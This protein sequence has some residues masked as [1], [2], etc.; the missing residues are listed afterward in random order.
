M[1]NFDEFRFFT[2]LRQSEQLALRTRDC[3]LEKR[4]INV[5]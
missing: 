4:T 3:D 5:R 1:G 2:G